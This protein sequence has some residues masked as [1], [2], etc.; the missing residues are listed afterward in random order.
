MFCERE[1]EK[2]DQHEYRVTL[3]LSESSAQSKKSNS[4]HFSSFCVRQF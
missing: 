2:T 3:Y 1:R 4:S